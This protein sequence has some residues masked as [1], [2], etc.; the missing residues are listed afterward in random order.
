VDPVICLQQ[1]E[2][3]L[4]PLSKLEFGI[5]NSMVA[6]MT[7]VEE[8]PRLI[9]QV[10]QRLLNAIVDHTLPP[11]C[12]I[13]QS[14]LAD[15]LGVSRQ[16]VSHALHLL[17]QQGLVT[18]AGRKGFRVTP[19][20]PEYICRLYEVRSALDALAAQLAALRSRDDRVGRRKLEDAFRNG[21]GISADTPLV[22]LIELDMAF[23]QALYALSGNPVIEETISPLW[24]HMGRSMACVLSTP[25]YFATVWQEHQAIT[26][27]VLASNAEGAEHAARAHA[28]AAGQ[29]IEERLKT[30]NEAA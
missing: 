10:Y 19:M 11:G 27:L 30:S 16:P 4:A 20:D 5:P 1:Q 7:P 17:H 18:E 13:R 26:E 23:H 9:D 8:T 6:I 15:R 12:R 3:D 2:I 25:R 22:E 24:P 29:L 14:E 28:L 21:R